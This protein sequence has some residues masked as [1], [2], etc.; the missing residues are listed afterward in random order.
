[1]PPLERGTELLQPF[2]ILYYFQMGKPNQSKQ[3]K[4]P[5]H[6]GRFEYTSV[7]KTYVTL[8]ITKQFLAVLLAKIFLKL[9][10]EY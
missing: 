7:N 8:S 9:L 1:M 10:C 2:M 6:F 3:T 4:N 5:Q